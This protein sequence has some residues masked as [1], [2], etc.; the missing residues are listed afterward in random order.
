MYKLYIYLIIFPSCIN[1]KYFKKLF[2]L[3]NLECIYMKATVT[4]S[5]PLPLKNHM[6]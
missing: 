5:L 6:L 2:F 1:V 4:K 3:H